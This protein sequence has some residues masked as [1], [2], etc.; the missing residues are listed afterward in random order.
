MA[1]D[2]V[3]MDKNKVAMAVHQVAI[4]K[5]HIAKDPNLVTWHLAIMIWCLVWIT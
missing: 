1:K 2:Q 3:F 4:D 5:D